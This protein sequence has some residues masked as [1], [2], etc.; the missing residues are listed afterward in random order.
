MRVILNQNAIG[1]RTTGDAFDDELVDCDGRDPNTVV[2]RAFDHGH[3]L[4]DRV[5][6]WLSLGDW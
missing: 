3:E 2:E 1:Y 4:G 5:S 6:D